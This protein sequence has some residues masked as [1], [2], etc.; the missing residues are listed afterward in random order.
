MASESELL[1]NK[2]DGC[3]SPAA[4]NPVDT[5]I[6]C[7]ENRANHPHTLLHPACFPELAHSC[8]HHGE[9]CLSFLPCLQG[10]GIIVPL[11]PR[12]H[13][14][15]SAIIVRREAVVADCLTCAP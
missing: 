10:C 6:L 4:V 15:Q 8:I 9:A 5:E 1:C 11:L 2:K 3:L 13:L 14:S 7:Q 12:R